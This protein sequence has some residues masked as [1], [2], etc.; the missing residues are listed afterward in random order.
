MKVK[1]NEP[2]DFLAFDI[3]FPAGEFVDVEDKEIIAKLKGN[4]HFTVRDFEDAETVEG[5]EKPKQARRG[6]A[7]RKTSRGAQ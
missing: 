2:R 3:A 4:S 7:K 6:G 1:F 5:P